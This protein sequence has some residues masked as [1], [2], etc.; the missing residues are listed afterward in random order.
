MPRAGPP[1][2]GDF[3]LPGAERAANAARPL[4]RVER[5]PMSVTVKRERAG[6]SVRI[7]TAN[8]RDGRADPDAL[9]A[10]IEALD[11]DVACVQ[12]LGSR[13]ADALARAL[14]EGALGPNAIRRGLGIACRHPAAVERFSLPERDAWVA[15]L[16][17]ASWSQLREPI[18]IINVHIKGPH[19][20]PYFPRFHT[21]R[22]QL[23][24]LLRWLE[25]EPQQ[26]RALLGDFN[27]S[28]IWPLYRSLAA[29]LTDVAAARRGADR[30]R[31]WPHVPA[32]GLAGLIQIDHCFLS[33][34]TALD[35]Q[36]VPIQGSDHLGLCVDV[37]FAPGAG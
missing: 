27:S 10:L 2:A 26:P 14:P 24:G 20:W 36:T 7:L 17:P 34:L 19:T 16:S 1:E 25:R 32:L 9:V 12:E 21:R 37:T 15:R 18:E 4:Q 6:S 28:P 13:Q 11:V 33:N 22:G 29:R 23:D 8:L 35:V 5:L 31:T 3:N 30:C